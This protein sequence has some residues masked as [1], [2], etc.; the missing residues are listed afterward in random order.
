MTL[1]V[2]AIV[3]LIA[4]GAP[5]ALFVVHTVVLCLASLTPFTRKMPPVASSPTRR[6]VVIVP[7]HNEELLI[8]NTVSSIMSS[9]YPQDRFE[10]VVIADNCSDNTARIARENGATCFERTNLEQR[11][12]PY[13]LNWILKQIDLSKYD[14]LVIIDADTRIHADFLRHMDAHL[15]AGQVALQGY[16]G[17]M[18]PDQ[19]WLTRL[20]LLPGTLKFRLH[21]PGKEALGLSCI[22]AGNGMCFDMS[23]IR[24]Y[25]WN[26]FSLTENWEYWVQLTL[27]N[28]RVGS[29][30]DAVIYSQVARSL[31][32]GSSQRQRW[33]KGRI[34]TLLAYGKEL[35]SRGLREPSA[36]K[37]DAWIELAR[38]SHAM[39]MLWSVLF[40]GVAAVFAAFS[41]AF[42]VAVWIGALLIGLQL[43]YF[44]LGFVITRPPLRTWIALAMIPWYLFWKLLISVQGI[45]TL[46]D[47]A[48]IRTNRHNP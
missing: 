9:N 36:S 47:R 11:G 40:I 33:M 14:A 23:L 43:A 2:L 22:L 10:L 8:A 16:F 30:P 28:V 38:P 26:A 12:K 20:S 31:Q 37:L 41:P 5:L 34:H 13:A 6:F 19:N 27:D 15:N 24:K 18:N 25:G 21:F 32:S 48:W 35:V 45:R 46:R 17:V 29:A 4:I 7:A 42:D 1:T 39:L 44:L 3:L